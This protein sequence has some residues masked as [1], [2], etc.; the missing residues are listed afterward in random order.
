MFRI[1]LCIRFS[2]AKQI[3]TTNPG[4]PTLGDTTAKGVTIN[5]LNQ[6]SRLTAT[7]SALAACLV[8]ILAAGCTQQQAGSLESQIEIARAGNEA[9]AAMKWDEY[10]ALLHTNALDSFKTTLMQPIEI[11]A[12]ADN[13]SDSIN[14]FGN[15]VQL[16][17]LR[18]STSEEFFSS[19][20]TNLFNVVPDLK[21]TFSGMEN[22]MV[23]AVADG[24]SLVHVVMQTRMALGIRSIDEMNVVTLEQDEGEWKLRMSNKIEGIIMMVQ[25]SLLQRAPQQVP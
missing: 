13:A 16:E 3:K 18:N 6:K 2:T 25:Q 21:T 17:N 5:T 23:G 9:M 19:L 7:I 20:M 14:L 22:R 15:N 10:A 12:R 8:L 24:D 11:L 1:T 4:F